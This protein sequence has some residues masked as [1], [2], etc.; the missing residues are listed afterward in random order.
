MFEKLENQMNLIELGSKKELLEN[1]NN[2]LNIENRT[3]IYDSVLYLLDFQK[4]YT[5]ELTEYDWI[6]KQDR[7]NEVE[8]IKNPKVWK[9]RTFAELVK[10]TNLCYA[11]DTELKELKYDVPQRSELIDYY[12]FANKLKDTLFMMNKNHYIFDDFLESK[13]EQ[14]DVL[15]LEEITNVNDIKSVTDLSLYACQYYGCFYSPKASMFKKLYSILKKLNNCES[16]KGLKLNTIVNSERCCAL[17]KLEYRN[18]TSDR[19]ISFSGAW[20][21]SHL[22]TK[23]SSEM[24]DYFDEM[25]IIFLKYYKIKSAIVAKTNT[26]MMSYNINFDN[27]KIGDIC[28]LG[29]VIKKRTK[30]KLAKK[31]GG[32]SE[33]D[34]SKGCI[35]KHYSCVERKIISNIFKI[36]KVKK[37][38]FFVT[39]SPCTDCDSALEE[40]GRSTKV[41]LNYEKKYN[42]SSKNCRISGC[43][44]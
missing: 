28:Y 16:A 37:I 7:S 21:N 29:D 15:S 30:I 41:V 10:F 23:K 8:Y 17:A 13:S 32:I 44:N 24:N 12:N 36:G 35:R 14:I 18:N 26:S 19:M 20:D 5:R 33:E 34:I 3:Y 42:K 2:S 38:I 11:F 27:Y 6:E 40:L 25:I 1:I 4:N 39:K 31:K 22:Y 43:G 9:K